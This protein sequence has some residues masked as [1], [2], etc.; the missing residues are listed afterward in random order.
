M[1]Q[2]YIQRKFAAAHYLP[3][4]PGKCRYTHGHTWKVEVWLEGDVD[5]KTGMVVDF[6]EIKKEIDHLDH[7]ALNVVLPL[8]FLP[9]TAEKLVEYFLTNIPLAYRVRVWESENAYAEAYAPEEQ[10]LKGFVPG[11]DYDARL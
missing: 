2:L 5:S 10:P 4:H 3:D 8:E 9:P 1:I 11:V 6:G 7:T